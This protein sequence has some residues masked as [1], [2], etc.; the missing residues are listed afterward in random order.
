MRQQIIAVLRR[1]NLLPVFE[2]MRYWRQSQKSKADNA[3]FRAENPFFLPPP[4]WCMHDMYGH[5]S[6]RHYTTSGK[7]HADTINDHINAHADGACISI[8]EWGC[9]LARILQ[10]F[11]ETMIR[12]GTDYN[13]EAI[14]WVNETFPN[15]TAIKNEMMPP[16][17]I[18]MVSQDVIYAISIFTHLGEDTQNSWVKQIARSLKPGGLFIF[19]VH[20]APRIGQLLAS[21]QA[22]FDSGKPVYRTKVKEGSRLFVSYH[23]DSAIRKIFASDFDYVDGPLEQIGQTLWVMR[24]KA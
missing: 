15:L 17:K 5:T 4:L 16:W 21:E 22:I 2:H 11:P 9:G 12:T 13:A 19:T 1:L 10:H 20:G 3:A 8:T 18:S 14:A 7:Q 6:Y 23:P 24:K